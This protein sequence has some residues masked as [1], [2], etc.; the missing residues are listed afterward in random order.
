MNLSRQIWRPDTCEC[1]VEEEYDRDDFNS[2]FTCSA[3][4]KKCDSH[5]NVDDSDL[6]GVLYTNPDGEN[7]LK[8]L[9]HKQLIEDDTLGL[10][11]SKI[12]KDGSITKTLKENI[13]FNWSFTGKDYDRVININVEGNEI[14]D[15]QQS[16]IN[17]SI[18]N[19]SVNTLG[20]NK[21][22]IG[23]PETT[24]SIIN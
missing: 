14:T 21:V 10:T 17:N 7:K 16:M 2:P 15:I 8:N 6:F 24:D 22:N 20:L 11:D 23:I 18:T 5:K 12:N 19:Y 9:I 4:I 3:V 13:D 1:V